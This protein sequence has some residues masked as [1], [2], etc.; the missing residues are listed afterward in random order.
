VLEHGKVVA[1][2][3]RDAVIQALHPNPDNGEK[4]L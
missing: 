1:D 2:G 3:P 4:G